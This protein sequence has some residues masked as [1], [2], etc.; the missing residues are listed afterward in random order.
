MKNRVCAQGFRLEGGA[1]V[2]RGQ[3]YLFLQRCATRIST[4]GNVGKGEKNSN[5]LSTY[6]VSAC[7]SCCTYLM[8]L[9]WSKNCEKSIQSEFKD[10]SW[11]LRK[12]K[13]LPQ[14]TEGERQESNLFLTPKSRV[15]FSLQVKEALTS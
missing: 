7:A 15:F 14:V 2:I 3:P 6:Y 8:P 12:T 1:E 10:E 11:K 5:V 9:N 13:H 4:R